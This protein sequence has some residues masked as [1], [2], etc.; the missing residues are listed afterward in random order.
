MDNYIEVFCEHNPVMELECGN[1]QC[2]NVYKVK[3]NEFF[4]EKIYILKC[5]KCNKTL[6]YD[7]VGLLEEYKK[8]LENMEE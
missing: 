1:E 4:K 3:S 2:K 6:E 8:L 7:S 5:E